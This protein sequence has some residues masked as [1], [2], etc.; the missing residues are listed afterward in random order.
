MSETK[1]G[2]IQDTFEQYLSRKD[3]LS[4]SDIAT[5][6]R[7]PAEY[8]NP[9]A[10]PAKEP[11]HFILG[12]AVHCAVIEPA[13]FMKRYEE[14]D[15]EQ[16]PNKNK[17]MTAKD[18]KAWK[19]QWIKERKAHGI[20][21]LT[22]NQRLEIAAFKQSIESNPDAM[23][24]MSGC[25]KFETSYYANIRYAN[26][27]FNARCRPDMMGDKYYVS[28]KTSKSPLPPKFYSDAAKFEYQAKEAFYWTVL[29]A[30]RAAM[31]L[32]P[33]ENGYI[34]AVGADATA[35]YELNPEFTRIGG[36]VCPYIMDGQQQV[37]I[38]VQRYLKYKD[39]ATKPGF[40]INHN[41]LFT[42]PMQVPTWKQNEIDSLIQYNQIPEQEHDA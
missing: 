7:S 3:C 4:S 25:T 16:R 22:Y 19:E 11:G 17:G 2:A 15:K 26:G 36:E 33:L 21:Y 24:I 5:L 14:L 31:G 28:I 20:E 37:H 23:R 1:L 39:A 40:E 10:K 27:N 38:A 34:I 30:V 18:N 9:K 6:L 41:N 13:E 12:R 29:N 42:F 8:F 35:V 32:R